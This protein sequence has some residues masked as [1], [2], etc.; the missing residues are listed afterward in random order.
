MDNF[1]KKLLGFTAVAFVSSAITIG[2]YTI[3]NNKNVEPEIRYVEWN[4]V[5]MN[6]NGQ[7]VNVSNPINQVIDFTS[8]ADMS[9]N[10]VVSIRSSVTPKQS[11]Q[12]HQIPDP[13][14][15]FF[16]GD[17]YNSSPTPQQQTSSGSGVI[18]SNDGYIITNNHVIEGGDKVEVILNDKRM[19]NAKIVG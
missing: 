8:V 5:G 10:A 3:L 19:F 17:G 13:F 15:Q 9:V 6:S 18:I 2:A 11:R 16:F 12:M 4:N 7:F 1:G 14:L